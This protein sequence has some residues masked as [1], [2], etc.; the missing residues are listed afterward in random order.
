MRK[1]YKYELSPIKSI[2]TIWIEGD[3]KI[4]SVHNQLNNL[5]IYAM[6][7]TDNIKVPRQFLI[8]TTGSTIES[9]EYIGTVLLNDEYIGTVLLNDGY[10]VVHVFEVMGSEDI[11]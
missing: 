2:Q 4:L 11:S 5:V 9:D 7:E 10:F 1:I 8:T 3:A 6:V